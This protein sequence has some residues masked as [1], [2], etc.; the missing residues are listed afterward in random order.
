VSHP[1]LSF[2]HS[3]FYSEG[4]K[5]VPKSLGKMLRSALSLAVW[6]M[7]DGAKGPQNGYTLNSQNFNQIENE[8]L[9][10]ILQRNF[11]FKQV[12]LHRDKKY[13]RIYIGSKSRLEFENLIRPHIV[14]TMSYKLHS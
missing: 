8:I 6:F 3:V 1:E 5:I 12:S 7:D 4:K 11:G 2:Y 10:G 13:Y 14:P 9:I